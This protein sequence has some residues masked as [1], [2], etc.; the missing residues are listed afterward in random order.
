MADRV[1]TEKRIYEVQKLLL[2][3]MSPTEICQKMQVIW[4]VSKWQ[5]ERY[6]SRSYKYWER[7]FSEKKGK[8]L[9]YQ[10]AKRADLY[11]QAYRDSQWDTC[12]NVAKDEAKLMGLYPAEK[13]EHEIKVPDV[14]EVVH[15]IQ[16][17]KPP[18]IIEESD[19]NADDRKEK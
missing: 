14:V 17:G 2:S 9:E 13:H 3:G 6:I 12:L 8:Q 16:E 4:G 15:Y 1:E 10:K 11:N 18:E 7:Y 5:I 19:A